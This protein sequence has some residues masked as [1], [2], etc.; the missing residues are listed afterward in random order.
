MTHH[1]PPRNPHSQL[2]KRQSVTLA[3]VLDAKATEIATLRPVLDKLTASNMKR[4]ERT[5]KAWQGHCFERTFLAWK[6]VWKLMLEKRKGGA[7]MAERR[8]RKTKVAVIVGWRTVVRTAQ[9]NARVV[10]NRNAIK[11]GA[12]MFRVFVAWRGAFQLSR[13][14]KTIVRRFTLHLQQSLARRAFLRLAEHTADR[15]HVRLQCTVL[16]RVYRRTCHAKLQ[17]AMVRLRLS[18]YA[19]EKVRRSTPSRGAPSLSPSPA[20]ALRHRPPSPSPAPPRV[21]QPHDHQPNPRP[22]PSAHN[23]TATPPWP[24][25]RRP[26]P[27]CSP[28]RRASGSSP[29]RSAGPRK[30]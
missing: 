29:R 9:R 22:S 16:A 21:V 23:G 8:L 15:V 18:T 24:P 20:V 13:R 3:A 14:E 12:V 28:R 6:G 25:S 1:S 30:P 27:R 26:T 7:K 2:H 11:Q 4:V 5:I 17:E 10:A 19:F